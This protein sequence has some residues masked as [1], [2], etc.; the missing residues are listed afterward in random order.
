MSVFEEVAAEVGAIRQLIAMIPAENVLDK[1]SLES[2]IRIVIEKA[3]VNATKNLTRVIR[4]PPQGFSDESDPKGMWWTID[5]ERAVEEL[6]KLVE[7]GQEN[8]V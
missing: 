1:M 8:G 4:T 2:R 6:V 3:I 7:F 5:G